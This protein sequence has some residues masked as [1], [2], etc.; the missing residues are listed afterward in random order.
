[1]VFNFLFVYIFTH[2][3]FNLISSHLKGNFTGILKQKKVEL[4]WLKTGGSL[5]DSLTLFSF[6]FFFL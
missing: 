6:F 4:S 5:T 3:F 2:S 1:M